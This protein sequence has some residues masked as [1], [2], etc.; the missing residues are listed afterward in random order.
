MRVEATGTGIY[1]GILRNPGD[2]FDIVDA[3]FSDA[4]IDY[5]AH[6]IPATGPMWGWMKQVPDSQ[7]L[8]TALPA[9]PGAALSRRTVY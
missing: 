7:P 2:V 9:L 6:D 8:V 3:D 4:S 1:G 5:L